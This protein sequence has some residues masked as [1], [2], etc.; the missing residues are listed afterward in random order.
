VVSAPT[1]VPHVPSPSASP[2]ELLPETLLADRYRIIGLIGTGRM[3]RVYA[4]EHRLL[5]KKLAIKVLHPDLLNVPEVTARFEREA[6]AAA[7]IGHPNVVT[8]TDFGRLPEGS[9]FLALE[10]VE[11]RTL[12]SE[13]GIGALGPSRSLHVTRQV[14][15][16]LGASHGLGIVHRDLKPENVMLVRREDDADFVKV[17]DFGIARFSDPTNRFGGN[18]IT[19]PSTVFGTPE[20]MAPEQALAQTV[21]GRA[22]LFS[23]GVM[24]FEMVTG[25]RPYDA[26]STGGVLSQQLSGPPPSLLSRVPTNELTLALD[27]VVSRL[28]ARSPDARFQTAE[29]LLAALDAANT[30]A[31]VPAS[32]IAVTAG[33]GPSAGAPRAAAPDA[34]PGSS[35][36]KTS[37][38]P[39]YLPGD[40]LPAF[41]LPKEGAAAS[42]APPPR[43]SEKPRPAPD[44]D[45]AVT[46]LA[47][48]NLVTA[49]APPPRPLPAP[50]SPAPPPPAPSAGAVATSVAKN[51]VDNAAVAKAEPTSAPPE[52]ARAALAD[53]VRPM[54]REGGRRAR[55]VWRD[56][57]R[58]SVFE[59]R[60]AI[61][62]IDARR[63]KLPKAL[64]RG[65]RPIPTAL[66]LALPA[67]VVFLFLVTALVLRVSSPPLSAAT[68]APSASA[69]PVIQIAP[70]PAPEPLVVTPPESEVEQLVSAAVL[71]MKA[72]R[73]GDALSKLGRALTQHPSLRTDERVGSLLYRGA[74]SRDKKAQDT[75]FALLEGTMGKV[76]AEILYRLALDKSVRDNVHRAAE[77]RLRSETFEQVAPADLYMAVKLRYAETC[78]QHQR[79]LELAGRTGEA[80]TLDV[81]HE[82]SSTTGCGLSG[83]EDCYPCLRE[84]AALAAATSAVEKRVAH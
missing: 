50:R 52:K 64:E 29:A 42:D 56:F 49:S 43:V 7:N 11:G 17:L 3:G 82:L 20:Y 76:G 18:A 23:L 13:L 22:D 16:A 36:R 53:S 60:K 47:L 26:T 30:S 33:K 32:G 38:L 19:R 75:A 2:G 34:A 57:R 80:R 28:L 78:E 12:R 31:P 41:A 8:A 4:A 77:T 65:L 9:L 46:R 84:N 10:F 67:L 24:L 6:M 44:D 27:A 39:T 59:Y 70:L 15:S 35:A 58:Q 62:F 37:G 54:L 66:L 79:L 73:E 5:R 55:R 72:A 21:D 14:A 48:P 25:V 45:D 63:V 68:S 51:M 40:P 69:P 81:L 74:Q 61:G 83:K 1:P 71:D